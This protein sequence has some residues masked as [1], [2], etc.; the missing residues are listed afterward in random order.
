MANAK[1]KKYSIL[2]VDDDRQFR[3]SLERLFSKSGY[4]V[5]AAASVAEALQSLSRR[6]VDLILADYFMPHQ[7]GVELLSR[8]KSQYPLIKTIVISAYG[9]DKIR[10]QC[11]EAGAFTFIDKPVK[12]EALLNLV[13]SALAY[14]T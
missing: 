7:H 4:A 10:E 3:L 8:I 9:D 14:N 12:K 13:D 11:Q 1:E 2:I 5:Q 6:K